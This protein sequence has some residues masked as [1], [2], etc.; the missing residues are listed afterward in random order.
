MR[1][2]CT[3]AIYFVTNTTKNIIVK[4]LYTLLSGMIGICVVGCASTRSVHEST[5]QNADQLERQCA[6]NLKMIYVAIKAYQRS[7]HDVPDWLSDLVP[8]Y[9]SKTNLLL[10]PSQSVTATTYPGL[11]DPNIATSYTYDFCAR[12]IPVTVWGGA[13]ATMKDW[14]NRQRQVYGDAVPMIRCIHHD[15]VLNISYGGEV[16]E[17]SVSWEQDERF[18]R[19]AQGWNVG[20]F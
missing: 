4:I 2:R 10:C 3:F 19:L 15:H 7:H 6:Q 17:S 9:I 8:K 13:P 12:Q 14:K 11:E 16:F 1:S 18:A 5:T 20:P